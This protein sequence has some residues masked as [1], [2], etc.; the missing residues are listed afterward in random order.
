METTLLVMQRLSILAY[1][2]PCAEGPE[3][4]TCAWHFLCKEFEFNTTEA[5]RTMG[6][7]KP[8]DWVKTRGHAEAGEKT[9]GTLDDMDNDDDDLSASVHDLRP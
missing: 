4:F 7:I 2:F 9:V 1:S 6:D 5:A 8:Y 3:V